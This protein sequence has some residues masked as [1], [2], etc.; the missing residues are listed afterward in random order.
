MKYINLFV[1]LILVSLNSFGQIIPSTNGSDSNA[2]KIKNSVNTLLDELS[3]RG[4]LIDRF[5][6]LYYFGEND[7]SRNGYR[8]FFDVGGIHQ[9]DRESGAVVLIRNYKERPYKYEVKI[10]HPISGPFQFYFDDKKG[11]N[12]IPGQKK[13]VNLTSLGYKE[14][15]GF[16]LV[17]NGD[18]ND[19]NL[20]T[21]IEDRFYRCC[22]LPSMEFL[23]EKERILKSTPDY[24]LGSR[25]NSY[26]VT[27]KTIDETKTKVFNVKIV[28]T[29]EEKLVLF[30]C[31]G[32][33][34]TDLQNPNYY[35]IKT[36]KENV[37]KNEIYGRKGVRHFLND[38][39]NDL[40]SSFADYGIFKVNEKYGILSLYFD[41]LEKGNYIILKPIY[42]KIEYIEGTETFEVIL[43]NEKFKIDIKGNR[44]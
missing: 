3:K 28:P 24:E 40:Q 20:N 17:I 12:T 35:Y 11:F 33:P 37:Y 8:S 10:F 42:D 4:S 25:L 39:Y 29:F 26:Y 6:N 22:N 19:E 27:K 5:Y 32:L 34:Q 15:L 44:I 9:V 1:F 16:T 43:N 21:V 38:V 14:N 36:E 7:P 41:D 2:E 13:K 18:Q 31:C 23:F 30:K